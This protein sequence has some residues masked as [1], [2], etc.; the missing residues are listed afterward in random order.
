MLI[1]LTGHWRLRLFPHLRRLAKVTEEFGAL[2]QYTTG[3][4]RVGVL[5]QGVDMLPKVGR[6]GDAIDC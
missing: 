5:E 1:N 6:Q 4:R 2:W 3:S